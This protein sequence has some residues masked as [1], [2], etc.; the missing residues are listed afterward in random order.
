[1]VHVTFYF[2]INKDIDQLGTRL[3]WWT[4]TMYLSTVYLFYILSI[5]NV[6]EPFLNRTFCMHTLHTR[7]NTGILLVT[8][9][10]H[11]GISSALLLTE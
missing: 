7:F 4:V 9:F 3:Q 8:A 2:M 11:Y 6:R 5:Q 1:M 10:L